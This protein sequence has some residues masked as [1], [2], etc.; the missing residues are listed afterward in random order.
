MTVRVVGFGVVAGG[1]A[2]AITGEKR[3]G[4]S[5]IAELGTHTLRLEAE[6]SQ[7]CLG[8]SGGPV[9]LM[10]TEGR[11]HVVGV[12]SHGDFACAEA[13]YAVRVGS[14]DDFIQP[15]VAEAENSTRGCAV[16]R[17]GDLSL[18]WPFALLLLARSR[19][20]G[21]LRRGDARAKGRR[22][23]G[24]HRPGFLGGFATLRLNV[25][26]CRAGT[27]IAIRGVCPVPEPRLRAQDVGPSRGDHPTR[28]VR[29]AVIFEIQP[30]IRGITCR[31]ADG[32][33]SI[34]DGAAEAADPSHVGRLATAL[35]H[36]F[37]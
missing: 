15:Y 12:T 33:A 3:D 2:S 10:G 27:L 19:G 8:D 13:A 9:F 6:P 35:Q 22:D 29:I 25:R 4:T 26:R 14:Y 21:D 37:P 28:L 30:A 20:R 16:G 7:P 36:D 5:R 23:G 32:N 18:A 17:S 1:G 31:Q 11:A 34:F 24:H